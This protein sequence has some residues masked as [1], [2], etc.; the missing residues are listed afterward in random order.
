MYL[1]KTLREL[2]AA[3]FPALQCPC[4]GTLWLDVPV[5][6]QVTHLCT[7][8]VRAVILYLERFTFLF[9]VDEYPVYFQLT[10]LRI[11]LY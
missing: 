9:H 11:T 3:N 10:P 6:A 8:A 2:G 4:Q 5:R 1:L 7:F